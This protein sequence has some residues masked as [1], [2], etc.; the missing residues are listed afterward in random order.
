MGF[1][2]Y[3]YIDCGNCERVINYIFC[4]FFIKELVMKGNKI[5]L[6]II[7]DIYVIIDIGCF[8]GRK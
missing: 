3:L 5:L 7:K 4:G 2:D 6:L 8:Y 1:G